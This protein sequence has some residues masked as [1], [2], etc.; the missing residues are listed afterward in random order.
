MKKIGLGLLV[1]IALLVVVG[2]VAPKDYAVAESI[3]V[4]AP[5]DHVHRYVGDLRRWPEWT[6]WQ[7]HD[8]TIV[9]TYGERTAGVGAS[10]SWA[11]KDGEGELTLTRSDPNSGIAYQMAFIMDQTRIP[12]SG[13]LAYTP[14]DGGTEVTW[15]MEG[16]WKGAVPPVLDGWMKILSPWMIGSEFQRGL[17]KL[18]QVVEV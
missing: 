16:S 1:V 10:Q 17:A 8:P 6:P 14:T 13:A 4:R 12:A 18:K 5:P 7:E 9:T 3:T 15:T 11:G 2:L